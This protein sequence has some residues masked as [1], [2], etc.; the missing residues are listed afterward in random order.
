[1]ASLMNLYILSNS[2]FEKTRYPNHDYRLS[3]ALYGLKQTLETA[4]CVHGQILNI[5]SLS[6]THTHT[7]TH[8]YIYTHTRG[9][10][11]KTRQ[12]AVGE[13]SGPLIF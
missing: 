5:I 2:L 1:M 4:P 10:P 11:S 9:R 12:Q 13:R 8:I 3:K 7:H 6:H